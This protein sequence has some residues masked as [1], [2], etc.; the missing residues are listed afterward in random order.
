MERRHAIQ[1]LQA[2]CE[3]EDLMHSVLLTLGQPHN[4]MKKLLN[5]KVEILSGVPPPKD[6]MFCILGASH[7]AMARVHASSRVH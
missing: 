7:F 5:W 4:H 2:V 3:Y 6:M 1:M